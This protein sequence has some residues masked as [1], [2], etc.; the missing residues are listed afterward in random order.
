MEVDQQ[1][2]SK[3]SGPQVRRNL[4]LVHIVTTQHGLQ[5]DDDESLDNQI[6]ALPL[7]LN[8]AVL[9]RQRLLGF[10]RQPARVNGLYL[11]S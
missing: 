7:N 6:N 5:F 8:A 10:V 3:A 4:R 1:S 11:I 2:A 9:D